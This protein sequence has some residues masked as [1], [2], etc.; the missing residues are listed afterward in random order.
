VSEREL[1]RLYDRCVVPDLLAGAQSATQHVAMT[2]AGQPGAGLTC[3]AVQLRRQ[4]TETVAT[5][6]HSSIDRLRAYHPIWA[7][8]CDIPPLVA[9]RIASDCQTW[10]NRLVEE[11]QKRR[12][13]LVA[14]IETVDVKAVPKVA[15]ELRHNRYVVQAVFVA[16]SREESHLAMVARYEMRRRA[17]LAVEQPSGQN[18]DLAFGNVRTLMD[19]I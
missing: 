9:A 16:T 3:A 7:A 10:F 12:L 14:E 2:I 5:A 4:L 6:V 1:R 8:G 13:D 19:A 17:G 18:H 11:V 15:S